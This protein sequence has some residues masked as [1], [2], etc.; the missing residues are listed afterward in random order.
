MAYTRSFST[1]QA[2]APNFSK[3]D[4]AALRLYDSILSGNIMFNYS[5]L[6]LRATPADLLRVFSQSKQVNADG[7]YRSLL[8]NYILS[9]E[10]RA[11]GSSLVFLSLLKGS[12]VVSGCRR[13]SVKNISDVLKT[14]IGTGAVYDTVL[15]ILKSS[16]LEQQLN[17]RLSTSERIA[18]KTENYTHVD[19]EIEQ[20][21]GPIDYQLKN[22]VVLLVDGKIETVAELDPLLRW[23]ADNNVSVVLF[24]YGY[25]AEVSSTLRKN[26]DDKKLFVF[27]FVITK[28]SNINLIESISGAKISTDTGIRFHNLDFSDLKRNYSHIKTS[29]VLLSSDLGCSK[30]VDVI[31]PEDKKAAFDLIKERIQLGLLVAKSAANSGYDTIDAPAGKL[32]VPK[33]ASKHALNALVSWKKLCSGIGCVIHT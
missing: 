12:V 27:P 18:I 11:A 14:Y 19:V 28:N 7:L 8:L 16:G 15:D 32:F 4:Q 25:A 5:N 30:F 22:S 24:S 13:S 6:V 10:Q 9:S 2:K 29:A 23:S 1:V 3:N 33:T 26:F 21:F 17:F 31:I 20:M